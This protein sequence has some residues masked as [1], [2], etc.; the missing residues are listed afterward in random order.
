MN[1]SK[2]KTKF[3]I[4]GCGMIA[5]VHFGAISRIENA[6]LV[7]VADNNYEFAKKFAQKHGNKAFIDYNDMLNSDIDVVCVCTPSCF[8]AP[9]AIEALKKGKHV[10]LEKPMALS[11]KDADLVISTA[12]QN[13]KLVTVISQLRFSDDIVRVKNLI[14]NGAFGKISLC[15]LSMK[16]YR[17]EEYYSSSPWKGT[18]KFDGGGALMNQGIHGVD[19]FQYILGDVKKVNG[20]VSTIYHDIE[21]EDT[22]VATVEFESGALGVI[23]AST[24]AYPGFER[25]ISIHGDNG[26]VV[27]SENHVEKIM[28]K[29]VEQQ[30][31][32]FERFNTSDEPSIEKSNTA[33]DPTKVESGLHKLQI[34]N[35][36]NAISGKATLVID[37]SEGK[38]A[39]KIIEEIYSTS[40]N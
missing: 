26:Y 29:G 37:A 3:G 18:L 5:N 11:T 35:L 30:I 39:V 33:S 15:E 40:K 17:T 13:K 10:V 20:K 19:L 4:L 1:T 25:K 28:I 6:E 2:N 7:G 27:I 16:Y 36:I 12:K 34:E 24:C 21:V 38:K 23:T 32:D 9:N 22:A 14:E 31:E 8:H